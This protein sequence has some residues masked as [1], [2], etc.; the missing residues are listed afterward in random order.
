MK[1]LRPIVAVVVL[2]LVLA[3]AGALAYAQ[4]RTGSGTVELGNG[5]RVNVDVAATIAARERGLSGRAPLGPDE[6]MYF[7]F[8][9]SERY[10]FWMKDM[11]FPIDIIWIQDGVVADITE[12]AVQPG[13]G[14][15]PARYAPGTAVN[16]V[17][18][19]PAGFVK[20]KGVR[21]GDPVR[22]HIDKK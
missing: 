21:V 18:E 16:R 9:R 3:A 19:V 1:E 13:P 14:E 10:L 4:R 22:E 8:P 20:A 15:E 2:G 5:I 17:L 6:G 7:V 12:N 11:R